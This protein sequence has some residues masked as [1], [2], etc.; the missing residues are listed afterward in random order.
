[1]DYYIPPSMYYVYTIV[2]IV[3]NVL[4]S[5]TDKIILGKLPNHIGTYYVLTW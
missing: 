2:G 1:M 4:S 3:E 5:L